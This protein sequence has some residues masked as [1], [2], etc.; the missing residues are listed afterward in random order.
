MFGNPSL[1]TRIAIGKGIG[2]VFGLT[3]FILLP[4]FYPMLA[5]CY[6]GASCSGTPRWVPSL[7]Y[8]V[9]SPTTLY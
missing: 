7:V 5:G 1:M 6:A 9:Y 2:F 3:G 4:Y 8:L